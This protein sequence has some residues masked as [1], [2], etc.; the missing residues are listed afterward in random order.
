MCLFIRVSIVVSLWTFWGS[1]VGEGGRDTGFRVNDSRDFCF[2]SWLFRVYVKS[3][4][5]IQGCTERER[6]DSRKQQQQHQE[7]EKQE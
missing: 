5:S 4:G 7:Q 6:A 2:G 1:R 3:F